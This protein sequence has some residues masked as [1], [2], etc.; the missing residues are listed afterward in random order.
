M[1]TLLVCFQF[2]N[3]WN[4]HNFISSLL[5]FFF[6]TIFF[7]YPFVRIFDWNGQQSCNLGREKWLFKLYFTSIFCLVFGSWDIER[8]IEDIYRCYYPGENWTE[9]REIAIAVRRAQAD[10][11][12]RNRIH[13]EG[14]GVNILTMPKQSKWFGNKKP[15]YSA[16]REEN[17]NSSMY[18]QSKK[19]RARNSRHFQRF[20]LKTK[21]N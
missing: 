17:K 15:T 8:K 3:E 7:F 19:K 1:Q 12:T 20:D 10:R 18:S 6:F 9:I 14:P 4:M 16:V 13:P 21:A 11:V 5:I 2:F